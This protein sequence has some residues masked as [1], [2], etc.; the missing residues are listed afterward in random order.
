MLRMRASS[1]A[2][3]VFGLCLLIGCTNAPQPRAEVLAS[4]ICENS[5]VLQR[6]AL[7]QSTAGYAEYGKPVI[8]RETEVVPLRKG[9]GFGLRWRATGIPEQVDITEIFTHPSITRP[10]GK[11]LAGFE[12]PMKYK[13]IDGVVETTDCYM[14]SEDY[15]LVAGDWTISIVYSGITLAK[16]S[17]RV[18]RRSSL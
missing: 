3:L 5:Q 12:E 13:A 15:E 8:T 18:E 9:I 14:L 10:D 11:T 7:P 17:Y 1:V 6:Y 16:R 4:G 2:L